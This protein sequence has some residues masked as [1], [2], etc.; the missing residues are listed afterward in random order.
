MD[1]HSCAVTLEVA[2]ADSAVSV[3]G[4][5]VELGARLDAITS[6]F[7]AVSAGVVLVV[8]KRG[9]SRDRRV[10]ESGS[11][12]GWLLLLHRRH[13]PPTPGGADARRSAS[14]GIPEHSLLM[15]R[16]LMRSNASN[17]PS[18][19]DKRYSCPELILPWALT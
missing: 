8:R 12:D 5:G 4:T 3:V 18:I 15:C 13:F 1:S 19:A 9:A 14:P 10:L 17:G 11:R 6:M 16:M 7:S 2:P